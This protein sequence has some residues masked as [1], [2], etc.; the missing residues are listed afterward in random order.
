M[1]NFKPLFIFFVFLSFVIVFSSC[2]KERGMEAIITVKKLVDTTAV[3]S[4]ARVEMYQGDIKVIGY[5]NGYGEFR[6]TFDLPVQ[7]NISV[8]KDSMKGIGI[9]NL[10]NPGEEVYKSVYIF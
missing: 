3:V 2:K 5:T 9:I 6:H 10:G 1:K 8:E 4:G 7:L